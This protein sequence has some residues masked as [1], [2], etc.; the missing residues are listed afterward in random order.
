MKSRLSI[1]LAIILG[2]A[3]MSVAH[4]DVP[5]E[6]QPLEATQ[7]SHLKL[8]SG[9]LQSLK[10]SGVVVHS[11]STSESTEM[12]GFGAV[13]ADAPI[14]IFLDSFRTLEIFQQNPHILEVGRFGAAP[15]LAD[16]E[17][18][19]IETDDLR[20][21]L[22]CKVGD[23][24]VK[25]SES[26]IAKLRAS[27]GSVKGLTPATKK[28]V[29]EAYKTL[30]LER[31]KSYQSKGKQALGIFVDKDDPVDAGAS[32][33]T[34][35]GEQIKTSGHCP[36]L[37]NFLENYPDAT[38]PDSESF[39]YWAKQKFG[40]LKP[41]INIVQVTIHKDGERVYIASKQIYSSHYTNAGLSV[42]ELMPFSDNQ[43]RPRT[44]VA[45]TLR[46]QVDMLGG[47]LGFMKKRMAQP[48]MLDTLKESLSG[49]RQK[50]EAK[51]HR[52]QHE[53]A[54]L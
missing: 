34:I 42:A 22:K 38:L 5:G 10:Q 48:R 52:S 20:G 1:F 41:V 33:A 16:L 4:P 2:C 50:L 18:L 8:G 54:G 12:A 46:M 13:L 37:Y 25:L 35:A 32:F 21:L 26:E 44:L 14:E 6:S 24:D 36:H 15:A 31:V 7:I 43:S 3:S 51:N 53:R 19:T 28:R 47:M 11:L 40:S 49:L 17:P 27:L 9:D 30:L 39:I 23:S 45:Y 29:A